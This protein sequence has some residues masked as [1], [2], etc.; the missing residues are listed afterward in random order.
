MTT[1]TLLARAK[2]NLSLGIVSRRED[3]YHELDMLMQS[4][5]L[6]D[7]LTLAEAD[8]LTLDV[9]GRRA[10]D[11]LV[12]RAAKALN[13]ACGARRGAAM[14]L[15]KAI[16]ARAGL[17]GGSADCAAALAGLD[18]LWGLGLSLPQLM[19]IGAGLGADV[20]F[21][22]LG[23]LARAQ[24]VGEKLTKLPPLPRLYLALVTPGGGLS[25]PE[26]FREWDRMTPPAQPREPLALAEALRAG[27]LARAQTLSGNDLEA[28]AIRLMPEIDRIL[29]GFR[30]LGAPF[31]RM[32][33]SGSTVYALFPD[34]EQAEAAA[35]AVPG[36]D[37]TETAEEG[38]A[39]V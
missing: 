8:G 17:G 35:R 39:F 33:G 5:G 20:P 13:A 28:P 6:A 26:V 9:D 23:G 22:L 31:V 25:T 2:V 37:V 27:D 24:G 19:E 16:P 30:D 7:T 12:L 1:L 29:E 11:D 15:K 18:R 32:S 38:W 10:E 34:R 3:G 14:S 4:I 21:C 36:A